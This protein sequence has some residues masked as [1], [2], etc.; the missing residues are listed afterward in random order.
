MGADGA[1]RT[2]VLRALRDADVDVSE[3]PEGRYRLVKGAVLQV[4]RLRETI[5]RGKADELGRLFG[6]SIGRFFPSLKV[7]LID[8]AK[9]S[10]ENE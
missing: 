9:A 2:D 5:S 3:L 1:L 7:V 4:V 6:V 8:L 10:G